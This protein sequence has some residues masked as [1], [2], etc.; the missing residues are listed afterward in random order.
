MNKR[1]A[2]VFG[3]LFLLVVFSAFVNAAESGQGTALADDAVKTGG[4]TQEGLNEVSV[5]VVDQS[6]A[7]LERPLDVPGNF[8]FVGSLFGVKDGLD[9]RHLIVLLCLWLLLFLVLR[10]VLEVTPF[11]GKGWISWIGGAIITMIIALS[12]GLK[13]SAD[14]FFTL[15]G[16]FGV[17]RGQSVFQLFISIFVLLF[18]YTIFAKILKKVVR[19]SRKAKAEALGRQLEE[20]A[21][22]AKVF[23]DGV[24]EMA[25]A[26][27]KIR[28]K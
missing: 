18:F 6:N 26:D 17:L 15:G 20:G 21:E 8:E 28:K 11:F 7:V 5:K 14:F 10:Q 13:E 22:S 24:K 4:K 27:K 19:E 23:S 12:G 9:L 25:Q 1:C 3:M 2:F 16:F